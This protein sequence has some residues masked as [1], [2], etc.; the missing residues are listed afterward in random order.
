MGPR[1][2]RKGTWAKKCFIAFAIFPGNAD[3]LEGR[4]L[5]TMLCVAVG[6]PFSHCATSEIPLYSAI[7][8][9]KSSE[10]TSSCL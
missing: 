6:G 10:A 3:I 8:D 2:L 1:D 5:H 9:A 4:N 7:G